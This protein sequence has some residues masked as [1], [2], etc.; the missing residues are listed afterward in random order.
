MDA[1]VTVVKHYPGQVQATRRVCQG[2]GSRHFP[3]L[4]PTEQEDDYR[5]EAVDT[6][7]HDFPRHNKAWGAALEDPDTKFQLNV[8][9]KTSSGDD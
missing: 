2:Q 4:T 5:G 3:Q 8:A 1:F 6:E 9:Q 7:R